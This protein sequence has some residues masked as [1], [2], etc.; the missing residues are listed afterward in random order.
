MNAIIMAAGTSS[1]FLPLSLE[2][3][4]GLLEV[5][6]EILI[7]RQIRQLKEA[8]VND[9]TIVTGYKATAFD[10]LRD[11]FGV[12]LVFNE[13]YNRYNNTSSIIRVIDLLSNTFICCSDHYFS[14]NLFLDK[15][16]ESYYASLYA[17]GQTREY[18]LN[19]D[20][21]DYIKD[22]KVGG[23]DSWYMAGHAYF[24]E[25]FS[26]KFHEILIKEYSKE[27]VRNSYW[28][29]VYIQYI[30]NLPMQIRR[31]SDSDIFEFDTLDELREFDSSY[32]GNTRSKILK[33]ICQKMSWKESEI[34]HITKLSNSEYS[35]A[36]SIEH[37][38]EVFRVVPNPENTTIEKL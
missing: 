24:T 5:K 18:C 34:T 26:R 12:D 9:I 35:S 36:F 20:S 31:Y 13:D 19:I 30:K 29:D 3:P 2:K 23:Q 1:R 11:K 17:K 16:D 21:H 6:G 38:K 28:E 7:E 15:S 14:R 22:V 10:Y 8:G 37:N 25:S 27:C 33:D 32:I 4:K